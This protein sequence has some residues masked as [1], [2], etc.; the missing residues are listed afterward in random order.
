M[1]IIYL[2]P[3]YLWVYMQCSQNP[4]LYHFKLVMILKYMITL[5]S[6]MALSIAIVMLDSSDYIIFYQIGIVAFSIQIL[7][8]FTACCAYP[9][10]NKCYAFIVFTLLMEL[11]TAASLIAVYTVIYLNQYA[12]SDAISNYSVAYTN[13]YKNNQLYGNNTFTSPANQVE[14]VTTNGN[15][16]I[17][18][19]IGYFAL[20]YLTC[21]LQICM[22]WQNA[23]L[24]QDTP[25]QRA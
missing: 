16:L 13:Y 2:P 25:L 15:L 8:L 9:K 20:H 1:S 11:C 24:N 10:E 23:K 22:R 19:L 21:L 14:V 18:L 6:D 3:F 4:R 5:F 17:G 12:I 7:L